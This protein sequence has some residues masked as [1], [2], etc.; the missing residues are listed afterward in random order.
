MRAALGKETAD[1]FVV[2]EVGLD[3]GK[4]LDGVVAGAGGNQDTNIGKTEN[5]LH[6]IADVDSGFEVISRVQV[7]ALLDLRLVG[8]R[9]R[10]VFLDEMLLADVLVDALGPVML[11]RRVQY[12]AKLPKIGLEDGAPGSKGLLA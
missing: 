9:P 3:G 7:Q 6:R 2:L 4:H 8:Q 11:G 1:H 5:P 10:R 12:P